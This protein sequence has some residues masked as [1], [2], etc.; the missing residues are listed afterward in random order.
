ME[1][2]VDWLSK[3]LYG[4]EETSCGLTS[5]NPKTNAKKVRTTKGKTIHKSLPA[6]LYQGSCMP[7]IGQEL[8]SFQTGVHLNNAEEVC[9]DLGYF[10]VTID[11]ARDRKAYPNYF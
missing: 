1:N 9:R 7:L 11:R 4:K 3:G 8:V 2:S 10:R 5:V 6:E